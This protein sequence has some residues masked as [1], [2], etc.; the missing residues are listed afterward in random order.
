MPNC[1]SSLGPFQAAKLPTNIPNSI[2]HHVYDNLP[3]YLEQDV[4]VRFALAELDHKITRIEQAQAQLKAAQVA[5][6]IQRNKL[7]A[8]SLTYAPLIYVIRHVPREILSEIFCYLCP[9]KQSY[10]SVDLGRNFILP[11]HVCCLW[12]ETSI[13]NPELWSTIALGIS[14]GVN[15][16]HKLDCA[17]A[18]ITSRRQNLLS[19][20]ISCIMPRKSTKKWR[21]LLRILLPTY[22]RW[23]DAKISTWTVEL[24]YFK[25]RIP[26]SECLDIQAGEHEIDAFEVAPS[27][28]CL[29]V[30]GGLHPL[31]ICDSSSFHGIS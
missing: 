11:S 24:S 21:A 12:R 4:K 23:K 28:R 27:L 30:C 10:D 20:R 8:F 22:K 29:R 14:P 19:V 2:S 18:W 26:S 25:H 6:Q 1:V 17:E 5:L 13:S 3:L 31:S 9:G 16:Q 15:I 7:E